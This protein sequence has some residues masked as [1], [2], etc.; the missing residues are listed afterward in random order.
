[1]VEVVAD[2]TEAGLAVEA[3]VAHSRGVETSV[4]VMVQAMLTKDLMII[5]VK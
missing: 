1:M 2:G 5:E 4:E 3:E